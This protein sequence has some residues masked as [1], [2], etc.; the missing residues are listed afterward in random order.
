MRGVHV[1]H[2]KQLLVLTVAQSE[3]ETKAHECRCE[4][5]LLILEMRGNEGASR[6]ST[7]P[8]TPEQKFKQRDDEPLGMATGKMLP[9]FRRARSG[10]QRHWKPVAGRFGTKLMWRESDSTVHCFLECDR[11]DDLGQ[12][13]QKWR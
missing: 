9:S 5:L 11:L 2:R 3:N 13:R 12:Q 4:R 10:G 6:L 7:V 1:A 8:G